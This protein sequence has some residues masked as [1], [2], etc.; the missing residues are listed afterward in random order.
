MAMLNPCHPGEILRDNLQAAEL[1][2][3]EASSRLGC[4]RQAL[5][6]LLNRKVG[7]SP[8]MTLA[9][10]RTSWSDAGSWM[11]LQANCELTQAR[12]KQAAAE[13]RAGMLYA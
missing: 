7:I 6:R 3:T 12:R 1:S 4:T 5:S 13:R 8:T 2:A 11:R 10:E 9:L